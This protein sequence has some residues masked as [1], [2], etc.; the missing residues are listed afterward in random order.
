M[1]INLDMYH[2]FVSLCFKRRNMLPIIAL[3]RSLCSGSCLRLFPMHGSH[4]ASITSYMY[5]VNSML[6]SPIQP[7]TWFLKANSIG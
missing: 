2:F 5:A 6:I 3:I 1:S 4:I 7:R